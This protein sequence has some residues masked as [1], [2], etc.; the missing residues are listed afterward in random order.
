MPPVP[1]KTSCMFGRTVLAIFAHPDDESLACGGTLAS[2]SDAGAHTVL[3]CASRGEQG[4]F[5][6]QPMASDTDLGFLRTHELQA[7]SRVLGIR[8][9]LIR[10]HPDGSLRW[11][12]GAEFHTEIIDAIGH[13]RPDAVITFDRDGLYWH[14]D[15][16]GVHERT[17]AAVLSVGKAVPALFCV[18]M[19]HGA[20]RHLVDRAAQQG[21]VNPRRGFWGIPPDAFGCGADPATFRVDVRPWVGRKMAALACHRTQMGA[22]NPFLLLN[23]EDARQS[24][25]FEYFR[26]AWIGEFEKVPVQ[27]TDEPLVVAEPWEYFAQPR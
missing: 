8:D 6:D 20:M 2:L 17:V 4:S 24:L 14:P 21:W 13:Y 25:G 1:A 27:R 18:T 16:I 9:V 10:D 26:R 15:H 23:E 5:S 3:L 11:A 7:A 22:S 19:L 12:E